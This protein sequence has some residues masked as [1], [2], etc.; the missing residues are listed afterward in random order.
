MA[1][2]L[3]EKNVKPLNVKSY[4]SRIDNTDRRVERG[5]EE[6]WVLLPDVQGQADCTT[7]PEPERACQNSERAGESGAIHRT[8]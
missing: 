3:Y 6:G 4:D 7:M 8:I 5:A 2:Y 1:H